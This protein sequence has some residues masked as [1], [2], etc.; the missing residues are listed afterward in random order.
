[1]F[2]KC[3]FEWGELSRVAVL[4]QGVGGQRFRAFASFGQKWFRSWG[5]PF[6]LAQCQPLHP[7][8]ISVLGY[9]FLSPSMSSSS[10]HPFWFQ[11]WGIPFFLTQCHPLHPTHYHSILCLFWSEMISILGYSLLSCSM[12]SSS[13][14][15][16]FDLGVFPFVLLKV[17]LFMPLW[18]Q[19]WGNPFYLAQCHP[20][21]P[22]MI[23][24]LGY[25]FLISNINFS[26]QPHL[27]DML[28]M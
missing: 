11:S 12:S 2:D 23:S 16:D 27:K 17:I 28:T 15:Y 9:S 24:I 4:I 3:T 22:I 10:S 1:M 18:F 5:I 19:S 14:Q 8:M 21:H 7:I 26:P 6:Y 25:S 13:S 20:F